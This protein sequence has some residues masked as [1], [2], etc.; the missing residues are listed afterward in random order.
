MAK[1]KYISDFEREVM[2][3]GHS[4]GFNA[5]EIARFLKR[6]KMVVYNHINRMDADGTLSDL[7]LCFVADEIAEAIRKANQ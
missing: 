4:R 1:A 3:I 2:R 7:P 6:G 5:P